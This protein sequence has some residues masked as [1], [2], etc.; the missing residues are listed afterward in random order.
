MTWRLNKEG[1]E[2]PWYA[3]VE[4]NESQERLAGVATVSQSQL[5]DWADAMKALV[6]L[7]WAL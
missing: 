6:W 3:D 4:G 1:E 2:I 7:K 5:K